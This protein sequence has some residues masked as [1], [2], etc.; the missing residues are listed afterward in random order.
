MSGLFGETDGM[1][2]SHLSQDDSCTIGEHNHTRRINGDTPT[3]RII[4]LAR[5][6]FYFSERWSHISEQGDDVSLHFNKN[7][8]YRIVILKR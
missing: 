5:S 6:R 8:V 4:I 7:L 1:H 2:G 3:T